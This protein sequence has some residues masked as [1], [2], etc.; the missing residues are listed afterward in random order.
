MSFTPLQNGI[1]HA[2]CDIEVRLFGQAIAGITAID[3]ML[4][5]YEEL[6]LQNARLLEQM[7]TLRVSNEELR[8]E[9]ATL[10]RQIEQL[11]TDPPTPH[12]KIP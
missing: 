9:V 7:G 2:W 5:K 6:S 10:H 4:S 3:E 11:R 8:K 12:V 1:E